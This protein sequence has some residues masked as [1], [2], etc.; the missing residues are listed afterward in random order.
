M[1][2]HPMSFRSPEI[3]DFF[4]AW[5]FERLAVAV[6]FH[7]FCFPLPQKQRHALPSFC[8]PGPTS[9]GWL[10]ASGALLFLTWHGFVK[11]FCP[12]MFHIFWKSICSAYSFCPGLFS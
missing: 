12:D 5:S 11:Y 4:H 1:A 2:F 6:A 9:H 7:V 10:D 3:F 8:R